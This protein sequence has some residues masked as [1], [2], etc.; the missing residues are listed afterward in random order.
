M[1]LRFTR[2][3]TFGGGRANPTKTTK[4]NDSTS[5]TA[6]GSSEAGAAA[7]TN[8]E[9]GAQVIQPVSSVGDTD[10]GIKMIEAH[11][12]ADESVAKDGSINSVPDR[13]LSTERCSNQ[14]QCGRDEVGDLISIESSRMKQV[15]ESSPDESVVTRDT[16]VRGER[17]ATKN[18]ENDLADASRKDPGVEEAMCGQDSS[19]KIVHTADAEI[20]KSPA[21][22][23]DSARDVDSS[24]SKP[25]SRKGDSNKE[26]ER[27]YSRSSSEERPRNIRR[28]SSRHRRSS[29]RNNRDS[30]DRERL[31]SERSYRSSRWRDSRSRSDSYS[32]RYRSRSPPRRRLSSFRRSRSSPHYSSRSPDQS[33]DRYSRRERSS[34]RT[35]RYIRERSSKRRYRSSS[36]ERSPY[37]GR[38]SYRSYWERSSSRRRSR[39]PGYLSP[40]RSD[41][42]GRSYSRDRW[43]R[44]RS[45]NDSLRRCSRSTSRPRGRAAS[46]TS[47]ASCS[48]SSVNDSG[49]GTAVRSP[50]SDESRRKYSAK[51]ATKRGVKRNESRSA[52]PIPLPSDLTSVRSDVSSK[53]KSSIKTITSHSEKSLTERSESDGQ[54]VKAKRSKE[55][56]KKKKRE[57]KG[58]SSRKSKEDS[59]KVHSDERATEATPTKE[60]DSRLDA[61]ET[62]PLGFDSY[63]PLPPKKMLND[64]KS[65]T[66]EVVDCA[67]EAKSAR[68]KETKRKKKKRKKMSKSSNSEHEEGMRENSRHDPEAEEAEV[69][70]IEPGEIR[71]QDPSPKSYVDESDGLSVVFI[72]PKWEGNTKNG[73]TAKLPNEDVHK[74]SDAPSKMFYTKF[75]R[76]TIS[77]PIVTFTSNPTMAESFMKLKEEFD[78]SDGPRRNVQ[79]SK[80][81]QAAMEILN[82]SSIEQC[83]SIDETA[84]VEPLTSKHLISK[85]FELDKNDSTTDNK[86]KSLEETTKERREK[87]K[88]KKERKLKHA[89]E[90]EKKMSIAGKVTSSITEEG[91]AETTAHAKG[92]A[93]KAEHREQVSRE[94]PR[95]A[96]EVISK[97]VE[98]A[99]GKKR[100]GVPLS[101][102]EGA[103]MNESEISVEGNKATAAGIV[104][105]VFESLQPSVVGPG[106]VIE[107]D[108]T[109]STELSTCDT[110]PSTDA[111]SVNESPSA[112]NLKSTMIL[113]QLDSR[114]EPYVTVVAVASTSSKGEKG[115]QVDDET[116]R[117]KEI[118]KRKLEEEE[119][120]ELSR[121]RYEA[122]RSKTRRLMNDLRMERRRLKRERLRATLAMRRVR[123]YDDDISVDDLL[124]VDSSET[125]DTDDSN[126]SNKAGMKSTKVW[127]IWTPMKSLIEELELLC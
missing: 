34:S 82:E 51:G 99:T 75:I 114:T 17:D 91:E 93:A 123:G 100:V 31:Y 95:N 106:P 94:L 127:F 120:D 45:L 37:R 124:M 70:G 73:A 14:H 36:R 39:S 16:S 81:F 74:A 109:I 90:R 32:P 1:Q 9:F 117:R 87:K 98:T 115:T 103:A 57:R 86:W 110:Q 67:K 112:I 59:A 76:E 6:D 3:A 66:N 85:A 72:G 102:S 62:E 118:M 15:L 92:N 79:A 29:S 58:S 71:E 69:D 80:H 83:D 13:A 43:S 52:S 19:R 46:R 105:A 50:T 68:D 113:P 2:K 116:R 38:S 108:A 125:S 49:K 44:R 60:S 126:A 23:A 101:G 28:S 8:D 26:N 104:E 89:V 56:K 77:S 121:L 20:V 10:A 22:N 18:M 21:G 41:G 40:R 78:A 47:P 63:G 65:E 7:S 64:A 84:G 12:V 11:A 88:A 119:E 96:D 55:K 24:F 30:F 97:E 53:Q 4:G 5:D 48:P 35:R 27:R 122:L 61:S 111:G 107:T 42:N 25:R 54:I 33:R